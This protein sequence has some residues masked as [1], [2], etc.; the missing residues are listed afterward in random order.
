MKKLLIA[1][2]EEGVRTLVR[3][4]LELDSFEILEAT[5]GHRALELA[6]EHQPDLIFLDVAMPGLSGLDVCRALRK[7]DATARIPVVMLTARA[8]ETDRIEGLEAGADHYF[9]KP[10]SPVAL[11]SK[12]T[13][14]LA[15]RQS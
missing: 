12:V 13:E 9:T 14:V 5:D 8:Q 3:M 7:E 1:D 15:E 11:L 6:R 4:T 2:D 10:F